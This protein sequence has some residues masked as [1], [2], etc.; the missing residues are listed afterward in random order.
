MRGLG[1]LQ[2]TNLVVLDNQITHL[3]NQISHL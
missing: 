1:Q 3:D 2:M